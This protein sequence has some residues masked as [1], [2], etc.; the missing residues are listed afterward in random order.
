[1]SMNPFQAA[2]V[3]GTVGTSFPPDFPVIE[4]ATL[5]MPVIGSGAAGAVTRTPVVFLHG[6]NDSPYPSACNRFGRMQSMAQYLADHGYSTS[7]LWGLTGQVVRDPILG[8]THLG[9]LNSPQTRAA[10]FEFLSAH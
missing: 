9:I 3:A 10:T 4:E 8:T 2:L 1:M 7:G 5:Q 6:N